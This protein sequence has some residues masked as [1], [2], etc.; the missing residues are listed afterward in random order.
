[1]KLL[2]CIPLLVALA[3]TFTVEA[4]TNF[5]EWG[6]CGHRGYLNIF[7]CHDGY[8]INFYHY[9]KTQPTT[10]PSLLGTVNFSNNDSRFLIDTVFY[11]SQTTITGEVTYLAMASNDNSRGAL[12]LAKVDTTTTPSVTYIGT[13]LEDTSKNIQSIA[14][15]VNSNDAGEYIETTSNRFLAACWKS[16]FGSTTYITT[17][18]VDTEAVGTSPFTAIGTQSINSSNNVPY[19]AWCP[20]VGNSLYTSL[21]GINNNNSGFIA[22]TLNNNPSNPNDKTPVL[23][24]MAKFKPTGGFSSVPSLFVNPNYLYYATNIDSAFNTN[25]YIHC[26]QTLLD[27]SYTLTLQP[28]INSINVLG[29][30]DTMHMCN[31]QNSLILLGENNSSGL[32]IKTQLEI[33][34][35]S[36]SSLATY[37]FFNNNDTIR[38]VSWSCSGADNFFAAE[39][40]DSVASAEKGTIYSYDGSTIKLQTNIW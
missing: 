10:M 32:Y 4:R 28:D 31:A 3:T 40:F 34:N 23:G 9:D 21:I 37:T 13:V 26:C 1:M 5:V 22:L 2:K 25:P 18:T 11:W 17:Y 38:A 8:N 16:Q 27:P 20:N 24:T 35:E 29:R 33:M 39:W 12:S 14:W 36:L 7:E 15:W 30:I 6:C 19:L